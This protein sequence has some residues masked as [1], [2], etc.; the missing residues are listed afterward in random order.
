MVRNLVTPAQSVIYCQ[1]I[2][3]SK[4]QEALQL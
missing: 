3:I 1:E 4:S 2:I